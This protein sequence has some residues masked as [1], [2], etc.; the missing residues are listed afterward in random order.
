[1]MQ[2]HSCRTV[3]VNVNGIF[4]GTYLYLI[5]ICYNFCLDLSDEALALQ[6]PIA[7]QIRIA[8]TWRFSTAI[9]GPTPICFKCFT[10]SSSKIKT[11]LIQNQLAL[12]L[13]SMVGNTIF[14]HPKS[15]QERR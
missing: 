3:I 6:S 2:K 14:F 10:I 7:S 12:L 1:M 9:K 11:Q 8:S 15:L 5:N 4:D 13:L